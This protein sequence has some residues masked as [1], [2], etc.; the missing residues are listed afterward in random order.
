MVI[1]LASFIARSVA[2]TTSSVRFIIG[3][4][5]RH[6][7]TRTASRL[8][9][10]RAAIETSGRQATAMHGFFQDPRNL[11]RESPMLGSRAAS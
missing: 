2:T 11:L 4:T 10:P 7:I 5:S 3:S 9:L 1:L 8:R 6:R